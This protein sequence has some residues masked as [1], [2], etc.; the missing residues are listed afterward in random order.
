MGEPLEVLLAV[1]NHFGVEIGAVHCAAAQVGFLQYHAGAAEWV[2][3]RWC[4]V[5]GGRCG[6]R[7]SRARGYT[8]QA[9]ADINHH[10]G[11]L[12]W[13]HTNKGIA[14]GPALVAPSQGGDVLGAAAFGNDDSA[15]MLH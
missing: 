12:G 14:L 3:Y 7:A 11:E 8:S 1:I 10:Q 5:P 13:Q 9:Q 2:Q 15:T 6:G 4:W